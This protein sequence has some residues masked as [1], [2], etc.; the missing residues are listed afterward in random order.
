MLGIRPAESGPAV[1]RQEGSTIASSL[2]DLGQGQEFGD[3][4]TKG[5]AER[6]VLKLLST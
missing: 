5:H 6:A 2:A 1:A 3:V 4:A